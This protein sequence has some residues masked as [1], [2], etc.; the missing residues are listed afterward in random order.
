MSNAASWPTRT[1]IRFLLALVGGSLAYLAFPRAGIWPLIIIIVAL[2]YLAGRGAGK[3]SPAIGFVAGFSFFAS[4]TWWLSL[5]LGPAP[6]IALSTLQALIFGAFFWGSSVSGNWLSSRVNGFSRSLLVALSFSA[7]W[8]AREWISGNYPYGG[9]PWGRL[10]TGLVDTSV[11]RLTWLGG[12]PLADFLIVFASVFAIE[13]V[14]RHK[15]LPS[16]LVALASLVALFVAPLAIP[17]ETSAQSGT[18]KIAAVQGNANA[19]L[20]ANRTSGAILQNHIKATEQL[21]ASGESFDVLV[22]PEN[23]VDLNVFSNPTDFR[24]I[25]DFVNK[26]GK[27]LIFGT[28][29]FRDKL[30]NTSVLWLPQG[31]KVDWYDKKKPVPFA[32]YVP[33]RPFWQALAPDLIGLLPYD[34]ASGTRDG[35]FEVNS[36]KLG[37]LICFEIAV[38]EVPRSLVD[39]GAQVIL[40]QTN[41]SDFGHSDEAFQQLAIA[42]IK[43]IETG[44]SIVNIST[45]GPSAIL[46]ADGGEVENI[47]AFK[48]GYMVSKVPLRNSITPASFIARPTEW[49]CALACLGLMGFAIAARRRGRVSV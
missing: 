41:N 22:W 11:A 3:A 38:D 19:G 17:I 45:V 18:L 10:V 48:P 5:Y 29:T 9:F 20:F 24:K 21:I 40:S 39:S 8:V 13:E 26:L 44:R 32:E 33:D 15:A 28:V 30:Y 14:I 16:R 37:A 2:I 49:V 47:D 25:A 6:L 46:L 42:R 35:I 43:A 23:A 36:H 31:G 12:M 7:F 4:Q 1:S 27:P 34:F